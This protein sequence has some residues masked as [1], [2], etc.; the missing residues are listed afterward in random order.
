MPKLFSIENS[1]RITALIRILW[2][3]V[4]EHGMK[5]IRRVVLEH[6]T[7]TN[8]NYQ[9]RLKKTYNNLWAEDAKG[10]KVDELSRYS[11]SQIFKANFK[12]QWDLMKFMKEQFE[13]ASRPIGSV[14]ALTGSALCAQ[15]TTVQEYLTR[16]WPNTGPILLGYLQRCL[17]PERPAFSSGKSIFHVLSSQP[18]QR[19]VLEC[20]LT[21]HRSFENHLCVLY[22][23]T[24]DVR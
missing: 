24:S 1:V 12:I 10:T 18:F 9:P 2:Q 11:K 17:D 21:C 4:Q 8:L 16:H 20:V 7:H 3:R 19:L 22:N 13:E 5:D 23:P 15:A 14:I 6:L